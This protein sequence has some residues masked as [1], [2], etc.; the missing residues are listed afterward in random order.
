MLSNG[1]RIEMPS[2]ALIWT[3]WLLC[4]MFILIIIPVVTLNVGKSGVDLDHIL[5]PDL[6]HLVKRY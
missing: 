5:Y 2:L 4:T 1:R 6:I 3:S